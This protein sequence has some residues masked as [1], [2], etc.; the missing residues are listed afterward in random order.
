[1]DVTV[2]TLRSLGTSRLQLQRPI[3]AK[4]SRNNVGEFIAV[5]PQLGIFLR[6]SAKSPAAAIRR[7][8]SGISLQYRLL[9][10]VPSQNLSP[11][12]NKALSN[13]K[14]FVKELDSLDDANGARG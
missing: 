12:Q 11:L 6:A 9:A 2:G 1:M 10:T 13:L 5:A 3:E 7:L 4:I 8:A 14:K